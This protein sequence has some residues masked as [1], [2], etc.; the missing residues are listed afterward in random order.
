MT[1][2]TVTP[3]PAFYAWVDALKSGEYTQIPY[4]LRKPSG[5]CATGVGVEIVHGP[6]AWRKQIHF[7]HMPYWAYWAYWADGL[8]RYF[9][10][11]DAT[12]RALGISEELEGRIAAMNDNGKSFEDIAVFLLDLAS[13]Y[14]GD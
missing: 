4:C 1:E 3:T 6:D 11:D 9:T 14:Q 7:G 10:M 13:E 2:Y 12:R 5:Y 8:P